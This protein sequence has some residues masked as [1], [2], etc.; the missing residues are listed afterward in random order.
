MHTPMLT[1]EQ[2]NNATQAEFTALLDGIYE[3]ILEGPE[4]VFVGSRPSGLP[5]PVNGV[6]AEASLIAPQC[7]PA[8]DR[9]NRAF[10][11]WII[12]ARSLKSRLA[13]LNIGR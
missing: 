9:P 7:A 12:S 6:V 2:L 13:K 8:S 3:Q 5:E 1:L 4:Q 10:C 11:C